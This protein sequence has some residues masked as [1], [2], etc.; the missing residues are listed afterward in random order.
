MIKK[1]N[2]HTTNLQEQVKIEI[3]K[4]ADKEQFMLQQSRLAQVGEMISMI[5]HQWRQPLASISSTVSTLELKI[6]MDEYNDKYFSTQLKNLSNYSQYLSS[7]IDDFRNFFKSNDTKQNTT[8]KDIIEDALRII[9]ISIE[10]K[11]I[12]IN[13]QYLSIESIFTFKNEVQQVVLNLLKNAEDI[14]LEKNIKNPTI[15][16]VVNSNEQMDT[17]SIIDN[18]G[19]VPLDIIDKIFDP[20]FTTKEK[21]D[22]T[23]LGLYMSKRIIENRCSGKL[24]IINEEDKANFTIMLP[25]E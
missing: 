14:L 4:N 5:A 19:G 16:I 8:T 23:G 17:I 6:M 18:A 21:R 7:T 9:Q 22:G 15:D 12:K 20:Y 2:S 10:A 1:I 24:K 3:K 11:G 13:K 25:R